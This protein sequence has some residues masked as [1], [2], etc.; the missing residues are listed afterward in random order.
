MELE[1]Y[2]RLNMALNSYE[3]QGQVLETILS[4]Q[5]ADI[6]PFAQH[7]WYN[8]I[9]NYGNH[10]K[11]PELKEVYGCWLGPS[12]GIGPAMTS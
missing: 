4:G 3:L 11:H 2:I 9:K 5:T 12:V 7:G 8:W 6:S 1:A 10:V